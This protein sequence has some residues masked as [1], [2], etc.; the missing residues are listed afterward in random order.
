MDLPLVL[1][2]VLS[3]AA[4]LLALFSLLFVRPPPI[5]SPSPIVS[6]VTV[7]VIP[8]RAPILVLLSLVALT[9]FADGLS[10]AIFVVIDKEWPQ[11]S[12]IPIT[13][14]AGALA[15]AGLAAYGAWKDV[16]GVQ[17][18][19][20]KRI[21]LAIA[22]SLALDTTLAILLALRLRSGAQGMSDLRMPLF[23]GILNN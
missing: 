15:Y 23:H 11:H 14:V 19:T 17:V 3:P 21:R 12:A 16:H 6:V 5:P 8:R 9:Y 18:W 1:V 13:A 22:V 10:F 7:N 20:L 4:V 2:R